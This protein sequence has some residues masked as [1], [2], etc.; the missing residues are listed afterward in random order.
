MGRPVLSDK[1]G[2]DML[3]SNY[4]NHIAL[5]LDASS[6]M[7]YRAGQLIQAV[8]AQ[9]RYLARRS[10]E[11]DQETRVT[12][13]TFNEQVRCVVYDKDVLRLPSIASL[14]QPRGRT[15]LID[16]V[17]LSQDDLAKTPTMYGDHAFLTYVFT[18]GEENASRH[19]GVRLHQLLT[20]QP[21]NWT[22]AVFVPDLNGKHEARRFGFPENNIAIWDINSNTG[23]T[24]VGELIRKTTDAYMTNRTKGIQGTR[25]L[26]SMGTDVVNP[27]TVKAAGLKALD[28]SEFF[29][30]PVPK[31]TVIKDFVESTGRTYKLGKCFY[32]LSKP[33]RIQANKQVAV[34]ERATAKVFTGKAARDLLGLPDIEVRVKPDGNPLF[35]VFVQSTS[36]NRKLIAGTQLL[37]LN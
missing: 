7:E 4:V 13:Y 28:P 22:V 3:D 37:M 20:T 36:I 29:L 24:E 19:S 5:V 34:V 10:Q 23:V 11:L 14:Y 12:I 17:R 25:T 1:K 26:F 32:E 35:K 8:D 2:T 27:D 21:D 15:A 6:S 9:I 18:D 33:E 16:A 31:D 30:V